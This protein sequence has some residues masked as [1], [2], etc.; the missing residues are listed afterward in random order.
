M[1]TKSEGGVM[2]T[3]EIRSAFL[4]FFASKG[5]RVVESAPLVP[6]SDPTSATAMRRATQSSAPVPMTA[7]AV[8]V[9]ASNACVRPPI[10]KTARKAAHRSR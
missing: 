6:L 3:S 5:H 1:K 2:T 10:P 7:T 9:P 8:E 4:E